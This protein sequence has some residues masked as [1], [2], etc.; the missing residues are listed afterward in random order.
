MP[1]P[2]RSRIAVVAGLRYSEQGLSR[3]NRARSRTN[4]RAPARASNS[5]LVAPAGPAPTTT[6]SQPSFMRAPRRSVRYVRP[7]CGDGRAYERGREVHRVVVEPSPSRREPYRL[8]TDGIPA[9]ESRVTRGALVLALERRAEQGVGK[10]P[11]DAGP[12]QR[13][14]SRG[15]A[16]GCQRVRETRDWSGAGRAAE[17]PERRDTP[18]RAA[19]HA[20]PGSHEAGRDGRKGSNLGGPRVGGGGGDGP[21]GGRPRSEE[22]R[23]RGDPTVREHLP[24]G[25]A[26][27]PA[28]GQLREQAPGKQKGREHHQPRPTEP[29]RDSDP[30]GA[31]RHQP[32]RGEPPH[33]SN[34]SFKMRRLSSGGAP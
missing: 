7:D 3:G 8:V 6:A 32:A 1:S 14:K 24:R 25:T 26:R 10:H 21:C 12:C 11:G 19:G 18:G 20:S 30:H 16:P 23:H 22:R 17:R 9:L 31:G 34:S 29:P 5:A 13:G 27:G 28:F 15:M 4:T 33:S 2:S